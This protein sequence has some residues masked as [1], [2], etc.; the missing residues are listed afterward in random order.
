MSPALLH[1]RS[2]L[3]AESAMEHSRLGGLGRKSQN[4][5]AIGAS[6]HHALHG[7]LPAPPRAFLPLSH[8]PGPPALGGFAN[9]APVVQKFGGVW[10]PRHPQLVLIWVASSSRHWGGNGHKE[11]KAEGTWAWMGLGWGRL[12]GVH[13]AAPQER[14]EAVNQQPGLLLRAGRVTLE[15]VCQA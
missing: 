9:Q 8:W 2:E 5:G 3:S 11:P 14:K 1:P 6:P 13:R 15:A 12:L 10:C 7:H 4:N